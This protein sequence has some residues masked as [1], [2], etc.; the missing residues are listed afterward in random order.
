MIIV[1][2]GGVV[3]GGGHSAG[4]LLQERLGDC[5]RRGCGL[6]GGAAGSLLQ[7]R[8]G[9]CQSSYQQGGILDE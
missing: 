7:G 2:G 9:D 5:V 4:S 3:C 1:W 6:W 8:L